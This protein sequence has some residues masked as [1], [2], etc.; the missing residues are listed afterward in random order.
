MKKRKTYLKLL[1]IFSLSVGLVLALFLSSERQVHLNNAFTR[2]FPPHPINKLYDL[3]VCFNS[4]YISGF[5]NDVL[6]LGNHTAPR[7][8][9]QINLKTRDTSH[10]K[11]DFQTENLPF[12]SIKVTLHPPYFFVMDGMVPFALRGKISKWTAKPWVQDAGYYSNAIPI[13]SNTLYISTMSATT[14]M[15]TLGLLEKND[16]PN[17]KLNSDLLVPQFD[18]VFDVDGTLMYDTNSNTLGYSYFYRNELLILDSKLDLITK[19]KTIDTITTAKIEIATDS[20]TL[21]SQMKAPPLVVNKTAI[22]HR[23]FALINSPRL[24]KNEPKDMLKEASI[25]DLYN[26]QNNSYEF[27]FYIYDIGKS[28]V[29][30]FQIHKNWMV[31]IIGKAVSVYRLDPGFFSSI[32]TTQNPIDNTTGQ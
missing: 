4:Y 9:L 23:K 15:T 7:H 32:D 5:E 11:I 27:S 19:L 20:N 24:G 2:R 8:L 29:K 6:Y 31:A 12:R 3:N 14:Q 30:E 16:K 25:I 21:V 28:K 26:W 13:D 17:L 22:L 1:G 18:G 10:V